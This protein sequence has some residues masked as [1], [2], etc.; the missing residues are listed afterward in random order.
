MPQMIGP[1]WLG[2]SFACAFFAM[3]T[4]PRVSI[5]AMILAQSQNMILSL[6]K[7]LA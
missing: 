7:R 3:I 2:A 4:A 5:G 6:S 1:S